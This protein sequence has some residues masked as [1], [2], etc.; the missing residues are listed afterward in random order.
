MPNPN[1]SGKTV[2]ITGGEFAG[3]EGVCL[4]QAPGTKDMW[5]VSPDCSNRIVHLR[6]EESFAVLLNPKQPPGTN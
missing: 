1:L 5:A 2:I 3:N 6:F 4:G